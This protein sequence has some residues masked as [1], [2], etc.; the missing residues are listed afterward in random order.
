MGLVWAMLALLG[1]GCLIYRFTGIPCPTC[2][3]TRALLAAA[4]GDFAAAFY[5]HPLFWFIPPALFIFIHFDR[6]IRVAH[7]KA[8][9]TLY[10][11]VSLLVLG[12]Y[13]YRLATKHP[14]LAVDL[15]RSIV[16]TLWRLIQFI[17]GS[18]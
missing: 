17:G 5:Y 18:G 4:S 14:V 2:G 10:T 1:M 9:N 3:M 12:V 13:A 7:P 16:V 11:L 8:V 6:K 15:E